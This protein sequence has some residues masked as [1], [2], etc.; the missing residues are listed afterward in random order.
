MKCGGMKRQEE[1]E[2]REVLVRFSHTDSK[3]HTYWVVSALLAIYWIHTNLSTV[4]TTPLKH[5]FFIFT[6]TWLIPSDHKKYPVF[7]AVFN[8]LNLCA[9]FRTTYTIIQQKFFMSLTSKV[10]WRLVQ[11]HSWTILLHG[12]CMSWLPPIFSLPETLQ[13]LPVDKMPSNV[14]V[15]TQFC[16]SLTT[17]YVASNHSGNPL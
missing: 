8:H 17:C 5:L 7:V 6:I 9:V 11:L 4:S 3:W 12:Y 14:K 15:R 16:Q 10:A 2:W 1:W 13:G